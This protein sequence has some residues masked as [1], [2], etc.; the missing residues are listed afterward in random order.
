[1]AAKKLIKF[2]ARLGINPIFFAAEFFDEFAAEYWFTP[3]VP[4][5][6]VSARAETP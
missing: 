6:R 5:N 1:V 2:D 4:A 3:V